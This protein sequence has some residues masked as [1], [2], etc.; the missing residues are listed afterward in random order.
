MTLRTQDIALVKRLI[1][2]LES[3]IEKP[4]RGRP[5]KNSGAE[6]PKR[7]RRSG[8]ELRAFRAMLKSERR[9]GVPVASLA[10]KHGIS[11][12]YIYQL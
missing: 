1:A 12:A 10:R 4:K 9:R 8:R 7:K 3:A 2:V 5:P 11:A 6:A